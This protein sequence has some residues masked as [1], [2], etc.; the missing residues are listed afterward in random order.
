MHFEHMHIEFDECIFHEQIDETAWRKM[1]IIV[2]FVPWNIEHWTR[3]INKLILLIK[4]EE[5]VCIE[6]E[7][8]NVVTKMSGSWKEKKN[9][10]FLFTL[11]THIET[12]SGR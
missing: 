1:K 9:W 5:S 12:C 10:I 2:D 3:E 11:N 7:K 8:E 4:S 6:S